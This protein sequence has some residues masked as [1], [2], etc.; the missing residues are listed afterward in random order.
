MLEQINE[1]TYII[2]II[3]STTDQSC[4]HA[5]LKFNKHVEKFKNLKNSCLNLLYIYYN[6]FVI[7]S[8]YLTSATF[9]FLDL[10]FWTH[11]SFTVQ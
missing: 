6:F 9:T 11:A 10:N 4:D 3:N 5:V 8:N 7:C 2:I 1:Q